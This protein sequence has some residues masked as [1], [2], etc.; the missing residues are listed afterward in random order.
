ML[1]LKIGWLTLNYDRNYGIDRRSG[2][3]VALDGSYYAQFWFEPLSA[4]VWSIWK[5]RRN[6]AYDR[7]QRLHGDVREASLRE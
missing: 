1:K 7:W 6:M 2:W 4:I 3:S 5:R